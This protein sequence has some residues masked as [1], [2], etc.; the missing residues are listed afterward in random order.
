MAFDHVAV[1]LPFFRPWTAKTLPILAINSIQIFYITIPVPIPD[2]FLGV[3][4]K[5][6]SVMTLAHGQLLNITVLGRNEWSSPPVFSHQVSIITWHWISQTIWGYVLTLLCCL[7]AS[8]RSC[9]L[10]SLVLVSVFS[11]SG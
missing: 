2:R 11:D 1:R 9:S 8:S 4:P 3:S 7:I 6:C 5:R 10:D